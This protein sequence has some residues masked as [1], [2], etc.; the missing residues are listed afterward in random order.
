MDS[1][2][3]WGDFEAAGIRSMRG[4]NEPMPTAILNTHNL[5]YPRPRPPF[6]SRKLG[7]G[8]LSGVASWIRGGGA[9][10]TP[11]RNIVRRKGAARVD[12]VAQYSSGAQGRGRGAGSR[13]TEVQEYVSSPVKL[14]LRSLPMLWHPISSFQVSDL[15]KHPWGLH[16]LTSTEAILV[17]RRLQPKH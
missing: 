14:L 7:H 9:G 11:W 2:L 13:D 6:S 3:W 12:S 5:R 17:P 8:P 1:F 16:K 10:W 15:F 4:S